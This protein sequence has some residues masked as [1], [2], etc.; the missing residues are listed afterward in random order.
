MR[1][2]DPI[3]TIAVGESQ[4]RKTAAMSLFDQL[5]R[6]AC[7]FE[8]GKIA[9]APERNVGRHVN[10]RSDQLSLTSNAKFGR[11]V[12]KVC[13]RDI[14]GRIWRSIDRVIWSMLQGAYDPRRLKTNL[15]GCLQVAFVCSHHHYLC[16]PQAK[17]TGGGLVNF[18][19]RLVVTKKLRGQHAVPG[20]ACVLRHVDEEGNIAI[21]QRRYNVTAAQA[22]QPRN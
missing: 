16:W 6:V 17:E 11:E 3:E 20:Q 13:R 14:E 18:L 1:A 19:V 10:K 2:N 5:I 8:E 7:P 21:R 22:I 9:L 4:G 12:Q 15:L